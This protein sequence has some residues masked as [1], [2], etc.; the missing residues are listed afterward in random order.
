MNDLIS[1][2]DESLD[3][4]SGGALISLNVTGTV[5]GLFGAFASVGEA[6]YGLGGAVVKAGE[7]VVKAAAGAVGAVVEIK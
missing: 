1:I 2:S 6:V 3:Q 4:V 5:K 7:T